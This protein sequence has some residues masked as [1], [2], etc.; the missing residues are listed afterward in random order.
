[1]FYLLKTLKKIIVAFF[2]LWLSVTL[3]SVQP[4]LT[5]DKILTQPGQTG[6]MIM[7][8]K[9]NGQSVC[10]I[11]S[12][13]SY[14]HQTFNTVTVSLNK[15]LPASIRLEQREIQRG[16]IR[17][18]IHNP[19]CDA[20][21]SG[22]IANLNVTSFSNAKLGDY[23]VTLHTVSAVSPRAKAIKTVQEAGTVSIKASSAQ[24]VISDIPTTGL[25]SPYFDCGFYRLRSATQ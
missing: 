3:A 25:T 18:I 14:D 17:V 9:N 24:P 12:D 2:S 7:S 8:L 22:S 20:I 6:K 4:A 19:N 23:A 10:A 5:L 1:M 15:Q 21:G 16:L 11:Q 13:I